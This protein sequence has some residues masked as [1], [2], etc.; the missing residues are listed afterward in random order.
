M[1]ALWSK[2]SNER[3][4][5]KYAQDAEYRERVVT[6]S[7]SSYRKNVAEEIKNCGD[8]AERLADFGKMRLVAVLGEVRA[9]LTFTAEEVGAA[10]GG[11]HV[12]AIR[13]WITAKKFPPPPLEEVREGVRGTRPKLYLES[14][15]RS[16]ITIFSE[17][18]QRKQNLYADDK[19]VISKLFAA[20]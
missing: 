2:Q 14:H 6:S 18:Q 17:F 8:N 10:L 20:V 11:Y 19:E 7:R 15:V 16:F 5:A 12:V 9:M 1:R 4:R 3:R 13:R